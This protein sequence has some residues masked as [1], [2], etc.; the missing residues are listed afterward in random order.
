[1]RHSQRWTMIV[2]VAAIVLLL[3]QTTKAW[4]RNHIPV[5]GAVYPL[6]FARSFFRL[7]HLTNTGVAFGFLQ[8]SS[9]LF[10]LI[11][12]VI[13]LTVLLYI[14]H[15]PWERP[16]VQLAT[17]LQLGG[18]LGNLLD[19]AV[20]GHVTDFLDFYIYWKGKTYHYPPFNIADASIVVGVVLL[21]L[22]LWRQEIYS[23]HEP[24]ALKRSELRAEGRH[25]NG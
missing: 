3:D 1:M 17:G 5:G 12:G 6:P 13:F 9:L 24:G 19:R 16:L 7:T 15:L 18:A 21:I 11:V 23:V 4:V 14:H 22:C 25:G 10:L 2:F 20:R 8:D